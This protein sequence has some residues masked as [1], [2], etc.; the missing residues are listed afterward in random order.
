MSGTVT[1]WRPETNFVQSGL[2]DGRY[3]AANYSLLCAGP[4][5]LANMAASSAAI[6]AALTGDAKGV[7]Q[8]VHPL[9]LIQQMGMS[10]AQQW[11]RIFEIGSDRSY[12]VPGRAMGQLQLGKVWYHGATLLRL[13]Y[14]YYQD[15]IGPITVDPMLP[16]AAAAAMA[17][18]HNVIVPPGYE[19]VFLNL[20]SD[21]FRQL[22]GLLW[23]IKD[24]N[25]DTMGAVYFE[26]CNIPNYSLQ[27][28]SQG[29]LFQ[30]SCGLQFERMI[31]VKVAAVPL[32]SM[33][34][35]SNA[36]GAN[37]DY[38]GF[39]AALDGHHD[40]PRAGFG[41]R[42]RGGR[43]WC[44]DSCPHLRAAAVGQALHQLPVRSVGL[45]QQ[46]DRC[47]VQPPAPPGHLRAGYGCH[48]A[49]PRYRCRDPQAG[50]HVPGRE[51]GSGHQPPRHDQPHLR[52]RG[53]RYRL[54]MS[55]EKSADGLG[56]LGRLAAAAVLIKMLD[57][58]QDRMR[59]I[60]AT[61]MLRQMQQEEQA[62]PS[63]TYQP[64][65][66]GPRLFV[67][68]GPMPDLGEERSRY[69]MGF[70]PNVPAGLDQGMVRLAEDLGDTMLKVAQATGLSTKHA[71]L[72]PKAPQKLYKPRWGLGPFFGPAG[73]A[74]A[75]PVPSVKPPAT[76]SPPTRSL[77]PTPG[78]LTAGLTTA[79]LAYGGYKAVEKG[80]DYLSEEAPPT[81]WGLTR[82]GAP[83]LA[84]T[85][86]PFGYPQIP[87][88][89][90]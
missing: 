11:S 49:R 14:A 57:S 51:P 44:R 47:P 55:Q 50:R 66:H 30:E 20:G 5:R 61:G 23:Y 37:V 36:S 77:A 75:H 33:A 42:H 87:M 58:H 7:G 54:R 32:I 41:L 73:G 43:S 72:V 81:D 28:D 19:N 89:S 4:P 74:T 53:S 9:G 1:G 15:T 68:A 6:G 56:V 88:R 29:L 17:N 35:N 25:K 69:Q 27:T 40:R 12:W 83:R 52:G 70:L 10:F 21:L 76:V 26:G 71:S 39:E 24:S 82:S 86:N 80:V 79:G 31:P 62:R 46:G 65:H 3:V 48:R 8:I 38:P 60:R 85:T 63:M 34:A 67:P 18:P 16:S 22:I 84:Q 13:M 45:G 78:G 64:T 59:S 90:P 2:V